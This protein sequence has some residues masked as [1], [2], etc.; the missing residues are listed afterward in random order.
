VDAQ[1]TRQ[2]QG[3]FAARYTGYAN[4]PPL[5]HFL[6]GCY[7]EFKADNSGAVA[8]YI[9]ELKRANPEH[10][11][12][13][14]VTIDGHVYEVGD[15]A[16]TFTIQSVSK[17]FVFALALDIVGP[18]PDPRQRQGRSAQRVLICRVALLSHRC[19]Q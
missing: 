9:P 12:V 3:N 14:L 13:A 15:R 1:V 4:E 10:F 2:T 8:D 19:G 18:A 6:A 11:G 16:V 17:A 5:K 7:E